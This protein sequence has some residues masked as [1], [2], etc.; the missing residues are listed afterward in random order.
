MSEKRS[1]H[2]LTDENKVRSFFNLRKYWKQPRFEDPFRNGKE[3]MPF[4]HSDNLLAHM[5]HLRLWSLYN[6]PT[7]KN[8]LPKFQ[9]IHHLNNEM[10]YRMYR[11]AWKRLVW[12]P[13]IWLVV[14]KF[15]KKYSLT[16][17]E[18]DSH[19]MC[20]RDV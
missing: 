13:V 1:P 11:A 2:L 14:F 3:T 18:G 12:L 9:E 16:M 15:G 8:T 20:W 7:L 5:Q 4:E 10:N 17:K 19:D 6:S